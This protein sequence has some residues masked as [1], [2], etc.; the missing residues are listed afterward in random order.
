MKGFFAIK[1]FLKLKGV[2]QVEWAW[3]NDPLK[4]ESK[5]KKIMHFKRF[6]LIL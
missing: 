1:I 4:E 5:V 6:Q 2:K 3:S